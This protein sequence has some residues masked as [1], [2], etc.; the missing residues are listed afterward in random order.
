MTAHLMPQMGAAEEM[1]EVSVQ[2]RTLLTAVVNLAESVGKPVRPLIVPTNEPYY[3]LARTAKVINAQE[4]IMGESNKFDHTDQLDQMALYWLNVCEAKPQPLTIR[5]MGK[6]RDVR[7]DIAGGS[8]IPRIGT[9]DLESARTLADLRSSWRGVEKLLL[10]Y[11][12]SALSADFLETVLSFIDP[13]ISI[14]LIDVAENGRSADDALHTLDAAVD[15]AGALGRKIGSLAASGDAG[16]EIVRAALEGSFDAIFMSL[17][18]EYRRHDTT[19]V[20]PTTRYV[21]EHAPCRVILG[22]PPKTIVSPE[23]KPA[24]SK[25]PAPGGP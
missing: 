6:E 22:F 19:A 14:T 1:P 12:G 24:S 5:V 8:H 4:L 2:D 7:L 23:S 17:R 20:A 10:A 21:L 13:A 15:R 16:R 3:A 9:R 11:D 25:I 18:G